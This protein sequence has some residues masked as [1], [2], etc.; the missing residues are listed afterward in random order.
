MWMMTA[1]YR[2]VGSLSTHILCLLSCGTVGG[3]W[4]TIVMLLNRIASA[5]RASTR[6]T[7]ARRSRANELLL[8]GLELVHVR[9]E[10]FPTIVGSSSL[11]GTY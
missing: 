3:M 8:G 1:A 11:G 6:A 9:L 5:R 10:G 4:R 2:G 7:T